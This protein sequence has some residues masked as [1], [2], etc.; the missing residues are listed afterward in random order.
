MPAV[1]IDTHK[2]TLAACAVDE[3]GAV[4]AETTFDNDPAGHAGLTAWAARVA[5]GGVVGF[6][7]SSSYGAAAA[8]HLEAAGLVVREVPPHLSRRERLRTRRAGKSDP[9]DRPRDQPAADPAGRSHD[10]AGPAGRRP[11]RSGGRG[12]ARPQPAPRRTSWCWCPDMAAGSP[13]SSGSATW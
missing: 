2:A 1:G 6:E 9:G 5:P 13:T 7:G 11:G 8:R 10:G 12:D 3:L 4:L